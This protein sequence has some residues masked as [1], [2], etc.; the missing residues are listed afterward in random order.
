MKKL[1][2]RTHD[3]LSLVRFSHT[4]FAMPFALAGYFI[5]ATEP[6]YGFSLRTFLLVLACMV[7]ARSAA[8]AFNRWADYRFD[9]MNPRTV[10]REIPSGKIS[11][12]QALIFVIASSLLFIISAAFLN[13]LTL[14]LSPVALLVVLGYSYTK[15]FTPLCHLVLG[16]GLSL[17]PTGAYIAVTGAFALL[18]LI[19]SFIVLTWVSGFDIIYSLQDDQFDRDAGLYSI[20][21]VMSRGRALA[22]STALHAVTIIL[23]ASAGIT[24]NAGYLYWTGAAIFTAMLIYQHL[25]VKPDDLSRVDMAFGTTNGIAGVIYG[26][27]VVLDL[28]L[29]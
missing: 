14:I 17:A 6:G 18:P 16:L 22:V 23:V 20:P 29:L 7:F 8:M 12:R 24:G 9:A 26:V 11:R 4:V 2:G 13:R 27:A 10:V 1:L 25:I 3:Y 28:L 19:Y 5:G 21:A 15:R